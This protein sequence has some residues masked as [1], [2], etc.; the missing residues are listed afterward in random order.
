VKY[1]ISLPV[2]KSYEDYE[3]ESQNKK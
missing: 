3:K 1:H 2:L